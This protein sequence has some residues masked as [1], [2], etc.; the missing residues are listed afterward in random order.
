MKHLKLFEDVVPAN[1]SESEYRKR[2]TD[3]TTDV[4]K[5]DTIPL[6]SPSYQKGEIIIWSNDNDVDYDFAKNY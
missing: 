6:R 4:S 5:L 2:N 3:Q 1:Q